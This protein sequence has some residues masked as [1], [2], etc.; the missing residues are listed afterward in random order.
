GPRVESP[1]APL[2]GPQ[3]PPPP[4]HRRTLR[5]RVRRDDPPGAPGG[6]AL[7]HRQDL[8][9]DRDRFYRRGHLV[10]TVAG[11]DPATGQ[12]RLRPRRG[13]P[14]RPDRPL[15]QDCALHRD[16]HRDA[17]H[18]LAADRFLGARS[19]AQRKAGL[20]LLAPVRDDA[21]FGRCG[22]R[23]L[24]RR[25][26][27][28][29]FSLHLSRPDLRLV[30]GR[31]PGNQLLPYPDDRPRDFLP[32]AGGDVPPLQIQHRQPETDAPVPQVRPNGHP[33]RLGD[34]H[35]QHRPDQHGLRRVALARLVR[36]RDRDRAGVW[37]AAEDDGGG[38]V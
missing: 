30:A 10:P 18:R 13:Q 16:R 17:G 35:P 1:Q 15:F 20:V 2:Q 8:H 19:D 27:R 38:G 21:V 32:D 14:D 23:L 31:Q 34:H 37:E 6:V 24:L 9:L 28:L 33:G 26:A 11:G 3:D 12:R 29:R 4:A 5:G 7:A 25:P 36:G 22:V